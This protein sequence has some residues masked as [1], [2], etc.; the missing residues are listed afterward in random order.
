VLELKRVEAPDEPVAAD[1]ALVL[2]VRRGDP[3]A[4]DTLLRRYLKPAFAVAYRI[5][6]QR[7]DAEDLVQEAFVAVLEHI[8][9]FDVQREFRPWLLRIVA[10]RAINARQHRARR[11]TES[12]PD[13]AASGTRSPAADV[14]RHELQER[15]RRALETLPER[16]RTIVQLSGFDGLNS[17]DIGEILQIP[18]GTV[19][20]ELHQARRALRESLSVCRG[21]EP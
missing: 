4:F 16:Q 9:S 5:L 19:R 6:G 11:R 10:N 12:I 8:D 18:A 3:G 21:S 2:Q 1:A 14:E 13:D 7:E 15:L 20:Y 17:T